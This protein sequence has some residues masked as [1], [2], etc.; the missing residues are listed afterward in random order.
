MDTVIVAVLL[1]CAVAAWTGAVAATRAKR[2]GHPILPW[3]GCLALGAVEV[4]YSVSALDALRQGQHA[5]TVFFAALLIINSVCLV[6]IVR[7]SGAP[8]GERATG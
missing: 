5:E 2:R 1:L 8:D 7:G 6:V 4:V 3:T